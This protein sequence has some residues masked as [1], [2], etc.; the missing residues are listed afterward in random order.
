MLKIGAWMPEVNHNPSC[1]F[2]YFF[3]FSSLRFLEVLKP[4]P[5]I[6]Y[7]PGS[8]LTAAT[9]G[10]SKHQ[11]PAMTVIQTHRAL[12][13]KEVKLVTAWPDAAGCTGQVKVGY[14]NRCSNT[15]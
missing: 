8:A 15:W 12:T 10:Q 1:P 11:T 6:P 13:P 5:T 3:S 14:R 7:I 4:V 2:T 9:T